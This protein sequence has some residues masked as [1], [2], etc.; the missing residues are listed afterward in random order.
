MNQSA[1]LL[2]N[3][4]KWEITSIN[5]QHT[6]D[7]WI[8]A[9]QMS[10]KKSLPVL[11]VLDGQWDFALF[12]SV[13]GVLKYDGFIDEL[14]IV[15]ISYRG[16]DEII[17]QQRSED[18][19]IKDAEGA[20]VRGKS[21]KFIE[22]IR[23]ELIPVI[24]Q[25][26]ATEL[27]NNILAGASHGGT[28]A[29]FCM[30]SQSNLFQKYIVASPALAYGDQCIFDTEEKYYQA[31][32][33][34]PV[35]LYISIGEL[36]TNRTHLLFERLKN[37]LVSRQYESFDFIPSIISGERHAGLKPETFNR[38]LRYVMSPDFIQLPLS[39]LK[40]LTGKY[41]IQEHG[42]DL[43][44]FVE[45]DQLRYCMPAINLNVDDLLPISE[46]YFLARKSVLKIM[47]IQCRKNGNFECQLTG[48]KFSG[49]GVRG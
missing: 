44:V 49:R 37:T 4:S 22:F 25:K 20:G 42:V 19:D 28:F 13:Y 48:G 41:H 32:S 14:L 46:R 26:Y 1:P 34:L 40:M 43:D 18:Y 5:T 16:S 27:G 11:Y 10:A 33:R 15:G 17:H 6:Y 12:H 24:T 36:E 30:F 23:S 45:D 21:T 29:L 8:F 38:G 2:Q 35:R 9:P 31:S 39:A 47:F 3:V 7:I